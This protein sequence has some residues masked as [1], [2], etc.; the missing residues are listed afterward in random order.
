MIEKKT[1]YKWFFVWD[2]D[3]EERWLNEMAL[4]GWV[5]DRVGW[6]RYDFIACEPGEYT[7]RLEMRPY[8]AQYVEFMEQS[9]A[10]YIGHVLQWRFFRKKAVDGPF[11]IFSDIDSRVEHMNRV[12]TLVT[13]LCVMNLIIGAMNAFGGNRVGVVN[14]LLASLLTYGLGRIHEK[15]Q[16]L[17]RDR[18]LYE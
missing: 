14:L 11:D 16:T 1:V 8:D 9:G 18:Q 10:E 3:K 17:V 4:A 15:K 13:A 6:C 2:F 7:I 5:L 12:G